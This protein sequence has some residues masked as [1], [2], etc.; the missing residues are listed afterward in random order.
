MNLVGR[1][2][3][4]IKPEMAEAPVALLLEFLQSFGVLGADA[5]AKAKPESARKR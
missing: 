4:P 3:V 1:K 2:I 5:R